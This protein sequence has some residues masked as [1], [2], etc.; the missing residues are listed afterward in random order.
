M[1]AFDHDDQL[2]TA[3]AWV[4]GALPDGEAARYAE[5]LHD[6]E[7]C[8]A[9][10]A[11]LQTVVDVLPLA[12]PAA[13]P[14]PALKGRIMEIVEREAELLRAAGPDADRARR[15]APERRGWW[16]GLLAR[17]WIAAAGATALLAIGV[18]GGVLVSGGP[19]TT[20]RTITAVAQ[21]KGA[22]GELIQHDGTAELQLANLPAPPSGHVYQVWVMRDKKP[23]PDAVFTVD[24]EGRGAV[25]LRQ[26]PSGATAVLITEEPAGGSREPTTAP[27]IS[28]TP[29]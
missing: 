16:A 18:V 22:T 26:D 15:P 11:R 6:C 20:T 12:A 24:R 9:E 10:V 1:S 4:L 19:E 27:S 8:R 17:P 29:A 21:A 14:P 28:V 3:G 25:A 7:T 2:A 5:H 23:R 13:D